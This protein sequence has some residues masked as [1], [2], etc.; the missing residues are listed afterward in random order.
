MLEEI[1]LFVRALSNAY[2]NFHINKAFLEIYEKA[3]KLQ[4]KFNLD[5]PL[6]SLLGPEGLFIPGENTEFLFKYLLPRIISTLNEEQ[7]LKACKVI[8]LS[9]KKSEL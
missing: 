9:F 7:L 8:T 2:P 6:K 3:D 4:S 5:L 1:L